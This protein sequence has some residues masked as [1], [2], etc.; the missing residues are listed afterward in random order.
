[1]SKGSKSRTTNYRAIRENWPFGEP[2]C[3][4]SGLIRR[5]PSK[6]QR[7]KNARE[8]LAHLLKEE[9]QYQKTP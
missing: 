9:G 6:V 7:D 5:T 1:M 8:H 2:K 4:G 3:I